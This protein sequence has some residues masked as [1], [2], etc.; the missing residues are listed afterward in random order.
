MR[1]LL[2]SSASL[3]TAQATPALW[4]APE[5]A[6]ADFDN[7]KTA[8]DDGKLAGLDRIKQAFEALKGMHKG[9]DQTEAALTATPTN[10]PSPFDNAQWPVGPVGAPGQAQ[11][12]MAPQGA[13][14]PQPRPQEAPQPQMAPPQPQAPQD[15]VMQG[16]FQRNAAL[17]RDPI[18]GDYLDP[19][20]AQA[21]NPGIF[22]GLFS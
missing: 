10:G 14:M 6:M 16:F 7:A 21:A 22:K 20:A 8:K 12:S 9:P 1:T 2:S 5:S 4:N 13:P 17:Q 3:D 15:P 19:T 11:A 18:S